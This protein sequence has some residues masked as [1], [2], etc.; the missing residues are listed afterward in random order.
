MIWTPI[1]WGLN[2]AFSKAVAPCL[3]LLAVLASN[4]AGADPSVVITASGDCKDIELIGNYQLFNSVARER[5]P[6]QVLESGKASERL[7]PVPTKSAQAIKDQLELASNTYY[8]DKPEQ[9]LHLLDE[10]LTELRRHPPGSRRWA[11]SRRAELMRGLFLS[12]IGGRSRLES[13]DES[14]R[15]VLRLD[16]KYQMDP[17]LF[18]PNVIAHFNNLRKEIFKARKVPLSVDSS[19][20]G[21]DVY[22]DGF[23]V[24][25]TPFR[26]EFPPGKYQLIATKGDVSSFTRERELKAKQSAVETID[27]AF[28]GSFRPS[29][30]LCF[31]NK[32]DAKSR[33]DTASRLA[34]WLG[35]PEAIVVHIEHHAGNPGELNASVVSRTGQALRQGTLLLPGEG[36]IPEGLEDLADYLLLGKRSEKVFAEGARPEVEVSHIAP[37]QLKLADYG[38]KLGIGGLIGMGVG[39]GLNLTGMPGSSYWSRSSETVRTVGSVLYFTGMASA[40][41]GVGILVW[42]LLHSEPPLLERQP[43]SAPA[44]QVGV[45]LAPG[46]GYVSVQLQLP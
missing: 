23:L 20:P 44:A 7:F 33:Q 24:G 17:L 11:L 42:G 36:E 1:R 29:R 18:P 30:G 27:L 12:F 26:G 32:G 39:T 34:S 45:G 25:K 28:E 40:A 2:L 38:W 35:V 46:G 37:A 8:A 4:L 13:A 16:N 41:A 14:F 21:A 22:L 5:A 31:S 9:S 6:A 15:R 10:A 3:F 43:P 19:P